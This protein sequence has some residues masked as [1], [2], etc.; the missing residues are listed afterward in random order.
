MDSV[1][2]AELDSFRS[3]VAARLGLQ[4]DETKMDL[5]A[6]VF[7]QRLQA[8]GRISTGAYLSGLASGTKEREE[9]RTLASLLTV[10]ET[11]FFRG[12]EHFRALTEVVL[13]ERTRFR[14]GH[15]PLRILSAGCASGDEAY[16]LAIVLRERFPDI[17]PSDVRIVGVDVNPVMLARA[18]DAHFSS[19]SLRDTSAEIIEKY[20]H[21][22]GKNF[23]PTRVFLQWSR[24]KRAIS[25]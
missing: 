12:S 5:L 18:K 22:D 2:R 25:P 3:I 9:L 7:R 4:F 8:R 23:I 10:G 11:Y 16:S 20:F 21:K 1:P 6:D 13:P 17:S 15:R 14:N 19:W 24:L